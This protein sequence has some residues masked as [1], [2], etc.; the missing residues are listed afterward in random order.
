MDYFISDLKT[1]CHNN[2]AVTADDYTTIILSI[3]IFYGGTKL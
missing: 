1:G 2:I 3:H